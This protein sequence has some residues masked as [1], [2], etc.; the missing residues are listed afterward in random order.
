MKRLKPWSVLLLFV[1]LGWGLRAPAQTPADVRLGELLNSGEL[2]Q[3]RDEYPRLR[4]SVSI[5]ML[6]LLACSQLGVGFNRPEEAAPA[7]DSLLRFHQE[8]LGA[9]ATFS[10][11]SLRAMNLLN[12]G[13]YAAAGA[14]AGD[15]VRAL[16]QSL[17]FESYFG[18]VFVE[19]IGKALADVPAPGLERPDRTVTVPLKY[20]AVGRGHHYS[21]PVEVNG[22]VHDFIFDT[23]CSFG[24]F[25]S[26]RYAEEVGLK[27]VADSIPVSGMTVGF[28]KLAT[29][30]SL[31]V[32]ELVYRH[33]YF[34]VAPPDPEVD[35]EFAFDGV[36]GCDLL[37]AVGEVVVDNET[38]VF[39]FPAEPSEGEPDMY[40]S[41]NIPRVRIEYAGSP[42]ELIFDT[43]NVKSDLD[44]GFAQR[45]P[46]AVAGLARHE[47]RH[48]G[49][50]GI[51]EFEAVT[52]PEFRFR[53]AG[54]DV[55]LHDTEVL[56]NEAE[57]GSL[58]SAG[59]LGADFVRS[60]RQLTIN[61][62]RM[63]IRGR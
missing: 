4:D 46:E 7:L 10:M 15:L 48:G 2:F 55:V 12:L 56:C 43:G 57:D 37:R 52:L 26:E 25:V 30:D 19:R 32:G 8:E 1:M 49:F 13:L 59:S 41:G 31:R 17:P 35:A 47:T 11:A 36:I 6:D 29:A 63:F 40:L 60:F 23:G 33:P 34:L 58:L 50:G 45:F 42:L 51:G 62:R 38:G 14:A 5:R 54:R 21:M 39:R 44:G 24:C 28:V 16:E 61:Y 9:E 53:A 18:L 22:H 20:E 27:V 3:L